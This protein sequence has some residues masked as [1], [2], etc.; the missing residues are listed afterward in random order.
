[1]I[2]DGVTCRIQSQEVSAMS[3]LP[4]ESNTIPRG[5]ESRAA[6]AGP[7]TALRWPYGTPAIV[8]MSCPYVVHA[9]P[10]RLT[11]RSERCA[12]LMAMPVPG[13]FRHL[14][15]THCRR[16]FG[17]SRRYR[18]S[19]AWRP[20]HSPSYSFASHSHRMFK[21]AKPSLRRLRPD[22]A[23]TGPSSVPTGA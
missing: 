12:E 13:E 20:Y 23:Q 9:S 16:Q 7:P 15:T 17:R 5:D 4:C 18:E 22:H 1:M 19:C 2:P 14:Y 11:I 10:I 8:K 3:R 21:F 6:V